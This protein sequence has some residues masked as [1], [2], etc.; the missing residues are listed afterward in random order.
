MPKA[1]RVRIIEKFSNC[2]QPA[3]FMYALTEE[4][5]KSRVDRINKHFGDGWTTVI[6]G[7][8]E[9]VEVTNKLHKAL[10]RSP[11]TSIWSPNRKSGGDLT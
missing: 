9:E 8:S 6:D 5:L 2:D 4:I 7:D 11:T 1:I 10:S 3:G